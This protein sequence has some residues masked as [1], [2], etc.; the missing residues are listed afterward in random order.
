M[1]RILPHGPSTEALLPIQRKV[2]W[3]HG[4]MLGFLALELAAVLLLPTRDP[5]V[6]FHLAVGRSVIEHGGIPRTELFSYS[7][8]GI[9]LAYAD[10]VSA[11]FLERAF[12]LMGFAGFAALKL[13]AAL[14]MG[15]GA[16]LTVRPCPQREVRALAAIALL[17]G[18]FAL[19]ERPALASFAGLALVWGWLERARRTESSRA[20]VGAA[21]TASL[22][23]FLHRFAILGHGLVFAFVIARYWR[24]NALSPRATR[25]QWYLELA[26][27]LAAL[28]SVVLTPFGIRTFTSGGSMFGDAHLRARFSE[29]Q[30]A[31]PVNLLRAFPWVR[32]S[33][34]LLWALSSWRFA[35]EARG[36]FAPC[37]RAQLG[38]SC[39]ALRWPRC[40]SCPI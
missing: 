4:I 21:L 38:C 13:L 9:P 32:C 22:W 16:W 36:E 35:P 24:G 25:K 14:A 31:T 6:Y 15:A 40:V 17:L 39:S 7:H 3:E 37:T 11:V 30:R 34:W 5:D 12:R 27:A 2:S 28:G 29:W 19:V 33:S 20:F 1:S 10:V 8:E 26:V 18:S 23:S